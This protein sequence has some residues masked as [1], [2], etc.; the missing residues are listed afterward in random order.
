[1]WIR[2]Q[3]YLCVGEDHF[4]F[5]I[6][7]RVLLLTLICLAICGRESAD[8]SSAISQSAEATGKIRSIF[9]RFIQTRF[10]V[11]WSDWKFRYVH[12]NDTLFFH[13]CEV[14]N[15]HSQTLYAICWLQH[16]LVESTSELFFYIF[17]LQCRK[18]KYFPTPSLTIAHFFDLNTS[19]SLDSI[20]MQRKHT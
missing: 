9:R 15:F 14:D 10:S 8:N 2:V 5:S 4:H 20:A 13:L 6:C 11:M 1:M 17:H 3:S 7:V 12:W 19:N 16:S 18:R